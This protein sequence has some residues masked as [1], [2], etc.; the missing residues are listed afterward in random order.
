MRYGLMAPLIAVAM[1]LLLA[2]CSSGGDEDGGTLLLDDQLFATWQA[3]SAYEETSPM[4]LSSVLGWEGECT[5][6]TVQ[7]TNT[8]ACTFRYY[9]AAGSLISNE[10]GT[11]TAEEQAATL[12]MPDD[13]IS[14][15]YFVFWDAGV[16]WMMDTTFVDDGHEYTIRWVKVTALTTRPT[17]MVGI[18]RCTGIQING[19]AVPV[20]D[21]FNFDPGSDEELL[22]MESDGDA[23]LREM[24]G[25]DVIEEFSGTWGSA[26][27]TFIIDSPAKE[28]RGYRG[29][30]GSNTLIF[31]DEATG[32]TIT[33][34]WTLVG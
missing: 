30:S 7:F 16:P 27:G 21:Y 22:I 26:G 31:L 8:G 17:D 29:P 1:A 19:A 3:I 20:A 5:K 23:Y 10:T 28:I 15:D 9:N 12:T 34:S 32:D 18:W 33:S 24:D 25:T 14:F 2:G 4:P 6:Q 13:T 11:Y